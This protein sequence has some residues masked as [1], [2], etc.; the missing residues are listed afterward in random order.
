MHWYSMS[1]FIQLL[2]K[3]YYVPGY[4]WVSRIF[5]SG[6]IRRK[7]IVHKDNSSTFAEYLLDAFTE[8]DGEM[9]EPLLFPHHSLSSPL[10]TQV[11]FSLPSMLPAGGTLGFLWTKPSV[12]GERCQVQFSEGAAVMSRREGQPGSVAWSL[13]RAFSTGVGVGVWSERIYGVPGIPGWIV[14]LWAR[15]PIS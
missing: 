4:K 6:E 10:E 8:K 7:W 5:S 3:P 14:Q 1:V 11:P 13:A 15:V 2:L 9:S 12:L